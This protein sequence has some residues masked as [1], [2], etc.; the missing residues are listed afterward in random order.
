MHAINALRHALPDAPTIIVLSE[1]EIERWEELCREHNFISP[2]I[3][4]GGPTRFDSVRNA[5][6]LVDDGIDYV[7]VHDGAR[8]FPSPRLIREVA[9]ALHAEGVDGAIP[10]VPLTDSVR[11]LEADGASTA[12]DRSRYRSVQTP[13]GFPAGLLKEAYAKAAGPEGFTDDASVMEAAGYDRIVLTQGDPDNIKIT[14]P[15][16]LALARAIMEAE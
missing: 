14:N 8:P 11:L 3:A 9:D 12:V 4:V 10:A 5:L 2:E 6:R 16:D 1:S 7:L 13:Q 15:H